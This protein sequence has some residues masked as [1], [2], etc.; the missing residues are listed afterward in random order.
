MPLRAPGPEVISSTSTPLL[1]VTPDP[2]STQAHDT[3]KAL[4]AVAAG[5]PSEEPDGATLHTIVI[6]Q[7]CFKV[8]RITVPP[9][10]VLGVNGFTGAEGYSVASPHPE[11][12]SAREQMLKPYGGNL[13]KLKGLFVGGWREIPECERW[14][15]HALGQA[16]ETQRLRNLAL[17]E[18]L[19]QGLEAARTL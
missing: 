2:Q 10:L 17:I 13:M 12:A 15:D 14:W 1:S 6:S 11:W 16:V 3:K 5:L 18:G 8:G 9:Q 4:N 7:L 19:R